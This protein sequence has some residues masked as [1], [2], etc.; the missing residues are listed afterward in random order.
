M[1][2][3][4]GFCVSAN[5][6]EQQSKKVTADKVQSALKEKEELFKEGGHYEEVYSNSNGA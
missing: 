4:T 3:C 5:S 6:E 2:N 1:G